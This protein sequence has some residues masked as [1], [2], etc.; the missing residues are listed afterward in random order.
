[1]EKSEERL[2]QIEEE[3]KKIEKE[4]KEKYKKFSKVIEEMI[5][6]SDDYCLYIIFDALIAEMNKRKLG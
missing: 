5:S 3:R 2:K 1:M 4:L 6:I